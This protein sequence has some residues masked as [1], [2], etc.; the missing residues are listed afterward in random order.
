MIVNSPS[1][2]LL[3]ILSLDERIYWVCEVSICLES[4]IMARFVFIG[5]INIVGEFK[6]Q[7]NVLFLSSSRML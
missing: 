1:E 6:W 2:F 3:S 7:L 5:F 4:D